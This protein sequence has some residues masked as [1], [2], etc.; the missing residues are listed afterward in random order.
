MTLQAVLLAL[1]SLSFQHEP[2]R[3]YIADT[4]PPFLPQLLRSLSHASYGVRAAAC[5]LAR[6]LSRS[7]AILR[8]SLLDSGV[9][10]EVV[11]VLKREVQAHRLLFGEAGDDDLGERSWTVEVAATATICNLIADFSPLRTVS[12][13]NWPLLKP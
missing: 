12:L 8:T 2:T 4:S 7:V 3:C 1:A 6:A 13:L 9:G 10:E 11:E 5:Q